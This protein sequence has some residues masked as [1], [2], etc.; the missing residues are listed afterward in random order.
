MFSLWYVLIKASMSAA[1]IEDSLIEAL[2]ALI[3]AS[4]SAANSI[5]DTEDVEDLF[6]LIEASMLAA[7]SIEDTE[8]V[9]WKLQ[10]QRAF[11]DQYQKSL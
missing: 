1:M 2:F 5:E 9:Q 11:H 10:I 7:N 4:M 3:E 8:D 6:A